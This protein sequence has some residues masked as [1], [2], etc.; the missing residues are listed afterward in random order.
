[1]L[2]N[3]LLILLIALLPIRSWASESMGLK[4]VYP[5]HSMQMMADG[6]ASHCEMMQSSPT[7]SNSQS[8]HNDKPVCQAC[9]LCMAFAFTTPAIPMNVNFYSPH[10]I[11]REVLLIHSA[12]LALPLKPPIF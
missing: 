7:N 3:C 1:M 9:S 2:R 4:M 6:D 8:E 10:L 12:T 11:V 5:T